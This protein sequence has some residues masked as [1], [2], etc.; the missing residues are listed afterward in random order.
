MEAKYSSEA[1]LLTRPTRHHIPV[2]GIVHS[3]RCESLKYYIG[4]SCQKNHFPSESSGE[5]ERE[6][7]YVIFF[8]SGVIMNYEFV[9]IIT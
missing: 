4:I 2:D 8:C 1:S 9:L 3:H 6:I 7:F 5:N